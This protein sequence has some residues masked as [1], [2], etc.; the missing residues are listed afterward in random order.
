MHNMPILQNPLPHSDRLL[1]IVDQ[2]LSNFHKPIDHIDANHAA[3]VNLLMIKTIL[4]QMR[5]PEQHDGSQTICCIPQRIRGRTRFVSH[6]IG[7]ITKI[8]AAVLEF[9]RLTRIIKAQ[10]SPP[11]L[12]STPLST[13][14]NLGLRR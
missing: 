12:P 6:K 11:S 5:S 2:T 3:F 9:K 10:T 4:N 13:P 1:S 14:L 7:Q 8:K